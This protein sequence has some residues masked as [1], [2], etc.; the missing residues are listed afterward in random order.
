MGKRKAPSVPTFLDLPSS[1]TRAS[2][3]PLPPTNSLPL[4]LPFLH[5]IVACSLQKP[6]RISNGSDDRRGKGTGSGWAGALRL[7]KS[8]GIGN[9]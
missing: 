6:N 7:P 2:A 8:R 5:E 9:S 4:P 1:G 3:R